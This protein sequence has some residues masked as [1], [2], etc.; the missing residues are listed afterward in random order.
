[1]NQ[2]GREREP[3]D[4]DYGRRLREMNEALIQS[5]VHQQELTAEAES[6]AQELRESRAELAGQLAETE[7]LRSLSAEMIQG[8]VAALYEKIV[9]TAGALM[10]SEFASMQI[11]HPGRGEG[12]ELRLIAHRGFTPEAARGWEWVSSGSKTA[13][14][15]ALAARAR[16]V[17]RDVETSGFLA[18]SEALRAYRQTGIRSILSTPLISRAGKMI[19]MLSTHWRRVHEASTHELRLFDLLTRQAADFVDRNQTEEALRAS[20]ER[21]RGLL[22]LIRSTTT[23]M[24]EGL[25][26]V[27]AEGRA[28]SVNPEAER[29]LGWKEAELLGRVMRDV[30]QCKHREAPTPSEEE[31]AGLN[32]FHRYDVLKDREDAFLRKDGSSV[33]VSYSS[34]PLRDERGVVV[35]LVVVFQDVSER[36]RAREE[37]KQAAEQLADMNRRK[38]EFLAM[39]SHELRNPLAP[40]HAAV[41]LMGSHGAGSADLVEKQSREIIERQVGNLTKIVNDLLEVSRVVN[42]RIRLDMQEVDLNRV[43]VQSLET[44]RSFAEQR[45]HELKISLCPEELW[46]NGDAIRLEEVLVNLLNNAAKYTPDGGH[47]AVYCEHPSGTDDAQIRVRD[48]GGGIEEELLRGG[49][50]FD[51]FTQADRSLARSAGG[52]G[53]GLSLAHRL[54]ALHGGSISVASPPAGAVQGSEFTVRLPLI[55]PAPKAKVEASAAPLPRPEGVR[56]LVVDDNVDLARVLSLTLRRTGYSVQAAHSGPDGLRVAQQWRPDVVLLD[57]G[58]PGLDGYEVAKRLREDPVATRAGGTMRLIAVTGYGRESDLELAREAGFDCHLTKPVGFHDLEK[59][60]AA[61]AP[62]SPPG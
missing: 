16:T 30:V 50:I 42:G 21:A 24:A 44:V 29:L 34:A 2:A 22:E 23:S 27:D 6:A 33:Q 54:V 10:H 45:K 1:M 15:A 9:D 53:I 38:D 19:G 41:H 3:P 17:V 52:L 62:R 37:L 28:T 55:V 12:G 57:I 58:L 47:I 20:E 51:L 32:A 31:C 46:V 5:S 36:Q 39:L 59:A 25:F 43:A 61:P 26:T 48:D 14:G 4:A 40:I 49:R 7:L 35:G 60:L 18:G 56:I 8:D 13:C 11:L